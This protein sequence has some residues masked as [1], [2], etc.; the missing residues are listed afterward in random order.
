[1][2]TWTNQS[3]QLLAKKDFRFSLHSK[4]Y[5][6][7]KY[8]KHAYALPHEMSFICFSQ[9]WP[10]KITF[11][12]AKEMLVIVKTALSAK[13]EKVT[14]FIWVFIALGIYDFDYTIPCHPSTFLRN[15]SHDINKNLLNSLPKS[16]T[17]SFNQSDGNHVTSL[18]IF[19]QTPA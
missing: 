12:K 19:V 4:L 7:S 15:S 18:P 13:R 1:M 16:C 14:R 9:F 17:T 6:S 8:K 3:I 10:Q 2:T 11:F 5:T